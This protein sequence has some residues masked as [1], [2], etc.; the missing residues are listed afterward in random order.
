MRLWLPRLWIGATVVWAL[1]RIALAK[2]YL[3]SFGLHV[4]R[5]SLIEVASTAL[6]AYSSARLLTAIWDR[7]GTS[8]I[9]WA[10]PTVVGLVLPDVFVFATTRHVPHR[11]FKGLVLFVA[12]SAILGVVAF[13]RELRHGP[14]PLTEAEMAQELH[15]LA[16]R[17]DTTA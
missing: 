9:E 13:L 8:E 14:M 16:Q 10:I 11:T 3:E 5:F 15:A 2:H 17:A 12:L 1:V 4:V 7:R 6:F